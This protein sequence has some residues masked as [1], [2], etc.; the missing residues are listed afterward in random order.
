VLNGSGEEFVNEESNASETPRPTRRAFLLVATSGLA[1]VG[2]GVIGGLS[3]SALTNGRMLSAEL[4]DTADSAELTALSDS[5]RD[6]STALKRFLASAGP[7]VVLSGRFTIDSPI[8]VPHHV[9]RVTLAAGS[10]LKVRGDHNGI[11]RMG[12]IVFRERTGHT[13]RE[14]AEHFVTDS[15]ARYSK[16]E[17]LLLSGANK[18][19]NSGDRYGYLRR[20]TS[21]DGERVYIDR[22]L[23]RVIDKDPRTSSVQLAPTI[24]IDGEGEIYNLDPRKGKSS[25]V[26]LK[27][28][29]KPE[30]SGIEVHS[31]GGIGVTVA[32]CHGGTIDC[33][34]RDLLDDGVD[35]FGYGVNVSGSSRDVMV[36]GFM[37]RVRHAVTTNAGGLIDQVGHAGEP[38]DCTFAPRAEDCSNK[39]IDTHRLGWGIVMIPDV[40]G[41]NGGVQVRADNTTVKGGRVRDVSVSGVTIAEVVSVPARVSG[42]MIQNVQDGI[43][44]RCRGPADI[45]DCVI[46][47]TPGVAVE[48]NDGSSIDG[49]DIRN[50]G[51]VR[52]RILGSDN[53]V[54]NV[55]VDGSAE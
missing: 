55:L 17:Y 13:M 50:G 30:V 2:L 18:V 43:G 36:G 39:A 15:P 16:N 28:V 9:Q 35:Y 47:D 12:S 40:S 7:A 52:I 27:A 45:Q 14:G 4:T 53:S 46:M 6:A 38:E 34:V 11:R 51:D 21:V 41:G 44:I 49:L 25:L 20:V 24:R 33:T 42:V 54:R 8:D 1:T 29:E 22:P 5:D 19:K 10:A 26:T 32:H 48:M 23:P 31:N 3:L 37:T